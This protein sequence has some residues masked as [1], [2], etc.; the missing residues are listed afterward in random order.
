MTSTVRRR[1]KAEQSEATTERLIAVARRLFSE[2]GYA[3]T[4]TEDIVAAAG[5]TRGALY[6]HFPG[7]D[8][9]FGAVFLRLH[10]E[11]GE[12]I[13][14]ASAPFDDIWSQII[15]G[16]H[17]FLAAACEADVRQ[18]VL[19]DG[20]AVVGANAW[21]HADERHATFRLRHSLTELN[22][23]L[24]VDSIDV[25]PMTALLNGALNEAALWIAEA[26][27]PE[28]A[29][30]RADAAFMRLITVLKPLEGVEG[31]PNPKIDHR[32]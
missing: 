32:I 8:A 28:D 6:H 15:A 3:H 29:F 30:R 9:L 1:T 21:R 25:A 14:A 11:I 22:A 17:A 16:C 18:I 7:K 13:E 10:E 20:P 27:E 4:A 12:R 31:S 2:R 5:V 26:D 24:G 23:K 19:R